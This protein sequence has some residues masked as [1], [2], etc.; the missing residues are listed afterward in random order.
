M[1]ATLLHYSNKSANICSPTSNMFRG[2]TL[3]ILAALH[4][5]AAVAIRKGYIRK[6]HH[7]VI[8]DEAPIMICRW[9][10]VTAGPSVRCSPCDMTAKS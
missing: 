3:S 9:I 8:E 1:F 5:P 4:T 6:A 2:R 10:T 7:K